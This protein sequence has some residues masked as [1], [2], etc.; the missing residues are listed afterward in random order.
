MNEEIGANDLEQMSGLSLL[1]PDG[2][3]DNNGVRRN[4]A[5]GQPLEA[6]ICSLPSPSSTAVTSTSK[7]SVQSE[8]CRKCERCSKEMATTTDISIKLCMKCRTVGFN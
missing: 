2:L 1:F 7:P 5:G 6:D 3:P 4:A 8:T